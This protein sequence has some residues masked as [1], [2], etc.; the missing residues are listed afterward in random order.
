MFQP[1]PCPVFCAQPILSVNSV[2]IYHTAV[3]NSLPSVA[4]A[5]YYSESC[6]T[7]CAIDSHCGSS[8][9]V[10]ALNTGFS[11]SR[12]LFWCLHT[13]AANTHTHKCPSL[14]WAPHKIWLLWASLL[15]LL[16]GTGSGLMKSDPNT[17]LWYKVTAPASIYFLTSDITKS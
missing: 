9:L 4:P 2:I 6:P 11:T 14:A 17:S 13:S 8:L 15:F 12:V 5:V 10:S 1:R 7:L 3:F 16:W